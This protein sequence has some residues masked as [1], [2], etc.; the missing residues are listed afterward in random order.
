MHAQTVLGVLVGLVFVW[1]GLRIFISPNE[2]AKALARNRRV[3][4]IFYPRHVRY[5]PTEHLRF[6]A[7]L[8][9]IVIAVVGVFFAIYVVTRT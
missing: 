5:A 2:Q 4:G 6:E 1:A 3:F 8:S 7:K 9:G